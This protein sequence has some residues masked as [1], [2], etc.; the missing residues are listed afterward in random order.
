MEGRRDEEL[1]VQSG[2]I[3]YTI[4]HAAFIIAD[5]E[6]A[7]RPGSQANGAAC[8]I[9]GVVVYQPARDEILC[10]AIDLP[11]RVEWDEYDFVA[12]WEIAIKRAVQGHEHSTIR[13]WEASGIVKGQ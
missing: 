3:G 2:R 8:G 7:I 12:G 9:A 5:V 10:R 1:P 4:D 13:Q 11:L 6:R